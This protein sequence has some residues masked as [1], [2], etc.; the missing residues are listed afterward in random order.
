V[1]PG[2]SAPSSTPCATL[3]I[4]RCPFDRLGLANRYGCVATCRQ[5][6]PIEHRLRG[7]VSSRA[8]AAPSKTRRHQAIGPYDRLPDVALATAAIAVAIAPTC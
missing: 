8:C 6:P 7:A 3:W 2:R 4:R 5:A 1:R